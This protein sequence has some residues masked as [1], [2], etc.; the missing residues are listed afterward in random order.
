MIYLKFVIFKEAFNTQDQ[1]LR[2]W[3]RF[4]DELFD[5]IKQDS[6]NNCEEICSSELFKEISDRWNN[7]IYFA[8]KLNLNNII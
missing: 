1:E 6:P 5:K 8:K 3:D 2:H 7:W 4:N